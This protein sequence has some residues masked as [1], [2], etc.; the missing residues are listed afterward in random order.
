LPASSTRAFS[1]TAWACAY[2]HRM[3][4]HPG[5][6]RRRRLATVGRLSGRYWPQHHVLF[7]LRRGVNG[8]RC[9]PR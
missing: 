5:R 7:S 1:L 2:R 6:S 4:V 9:R 8:S 3:A